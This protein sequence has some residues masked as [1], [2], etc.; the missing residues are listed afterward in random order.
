MRKLYAV[1]LTVVTSLLANV[2]TVYADGN[3]YGPYNPYDHKPIPTG[4]E[5][6]TIFYIAAVITFTTGMII[7]STVKNLKAKQSI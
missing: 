6:T 5:D 2:S 4:F 1:T 3:P 7:L